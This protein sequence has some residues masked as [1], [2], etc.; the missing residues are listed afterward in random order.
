M[1][2]FRLKLQRLLPTLVLTC[3]IGLS[4]PATSLAWAESPKAAESA[5]ATLFRDKG[6]AYCHGANAQGTA[7]GPSLANVRKLMKPAQI[8]A[9]IENGGQKMPSF[10][11]SLSHD[12]VLQLVAFLRAKHRPA[13]S[14][15][16]EPAKT[17]APVSNP[18]Q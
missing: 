9:Q 10:S 6:C 16:P 12:E 3:T 4:L 2:A 17:S 15:V 13:P 8:S 11:D 14:A 7:K 18:G 5:G 1:I